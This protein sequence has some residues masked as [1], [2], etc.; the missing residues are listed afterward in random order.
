MIIKKGGIKMKNRMNTKTEKSKYGTQL[1]LLSTCTLIIL[2]SVIFYG[3]RSSYAIVEPT[4]SNNPFENYY[5]NPAYVKYYNSNIEEKKQYKLIPTKYILK[6]T[7]SSSNNMLSSVTSIFSKKKASST[8]L[9]SYY[10]LKDEGMIT[11]VK[12][13]GYANLCWAFAS[14]AALEGTLLKKG[15]VTNKDSL[16]LS[17]RQLDFATAKEENFV[18]HFNPYSLN[19]S[20]LSGGNFERAWKSLASGV[21]PITTKKFGEYSDSDIS[22]KSIKDVLDTKN[23]E[24]SVDGH[25]QY[26]GTYVNDDIF[27]EPGSPISDSDRYS[28]IQKL[29]EHIYNNGP[30]FFGSPIS[31]GLNNRYNYRDLDHNQYLLNVFETNFYE[32]AQMSPHAMT[33]IGWDDQYTYDYCYTSDSL[34]SRA[35][36]SDEEVTWKNDGI[37]ECP[38][39]AVGTGAFIVKNSWGESNNPYLYLA[40]SSHINEIIGITE[41]S[42]KN[43]DMNYDATKAYEIVDNYKSSEITEAGN[44]K[45]VVIKYG[46]SSAI[47]E[48]LQKVSFSYTGKGDNNLSVYFSNNGKDYIYTGSIAVNEVGSYTLKVNDLKLTNNQFYLKFSFESKDVSLSDINAFSTYTDNDSNILAD[49]VIDHLDDYTIADDKILLYTVTRNIDSGNTIEYKLY[50]KNN[51][52]ISDTMTVEQNIVLNNFVKP[53][54]KLKTR[55]VGNYVLKTIYNGNVLDSEN[56]E[57]KN[58]KSLWKAGDGSLDNPYIIET[59]EDFI[60]IFTDKR[61]MSV[62]YKLGNSIDFSDIENWDAS[63]YYKNTSS[64]FSGTFDGENYAISGISCNSLFCSLFPEIENGTIKNIIFKNININYYLES[65]STISTK[66]FILSNNIDNS[67]IE[68]IVVE[69]SVSIHSNTNVASLIGNAQNSKIA[70]VANYANI[71]SVA[72]EN[73]TTAG[74]VACAYDTEID[75]CYNY[76]NITGLA[77]TGGIVGYMLSTNIFRGVSGPEEEPL[78]SVTNSYNLGIITSKCSDLW[79]SHGGVGGIAGDISYGTLENCYDN[80]KYLET[81]VAYG[82]LIGTADS[83]MINNSYYILDNKKSS[84][85]KNRGSIETNVLAKTDAE[86]KLQSTFKGFDFVNIWSISE[87]NYPTLK[88]INLTQNSN[89][90][91]DN[92]EDDKKNEGTVDNKND[93]SVTNPQPSD[94]NGNIEPPFTVDKIYTYIVILLFDTIAVILVII[95]IKRNKKVQ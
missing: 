3:F 95:A 31:P 77:D 72:D 84:I 36:S 30:I 60:N 39:N 55:K 46:R 34:S 63:K 93:D 19:R 58:L 50:D 71:T 5:L 51:N 24:Y 62:N 43:W 7:N 32:Y 89:K 92:T 15:V 67:T 44:E 21:S 40:Y 35:T 69:N 45:N 11:A 16:S 78:T 2:G 85:G 12:N 56:I 26:G 23:V 47:P 57:I 9:P 29:K 64:K 75:Q 68:N 74:I 18:E 49:T 25:I 61:Y 20:L 54:I 52:D 14:N 6:Y 41:V 65:E 82:H 38:N 87:N 81:N 76:G 90:E 59:K 73:T 4:E 48:I 83:V 1:A 94:N 28:L 17:E 66:G 79:C 86:L 42:Q 8:N 10:N 37:R 70:K 88:N 13:Q 22:K 27:L 80:S 91:E 33:I 53:V